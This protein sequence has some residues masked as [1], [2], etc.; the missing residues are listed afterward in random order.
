MEIDLIHSFLIHP[1]KGQEEP[2]EIK[3]ATVT[4]KSTHLYKMLKQV[5]DAAGDECQHDIS[6]SPDEAG[7]QTNVCRALIINYLKNRNL[8]TARKIAERLQAVTTNK[9]GLGLL[10]L[11]SGQKNS[12]S[13]IVIS[14]FRADSGI[15]A[16]EQEETLNVEYL[17]RIFMKNAASYKAA[18]YTGKSYD[19]DFWKGRAIDKQI[20]SKESYISDYWIRDFLNSSFLTTGEAGT[21]RFAD[22][23]KKTMN[24]TSIPA[25]KDE[26][27]ALCKLLPGKDGKVLNASQ[28]LKQHGI[29]KTTQDLI[30]ENFPR[31]ALFH[32]SFKFISEELTKFIAFKTVELSNGGILT[33][34]TQKFDDIFQKETINGESV[35]FSTEGQIVDQRFRK[36]S[37]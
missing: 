22:A 9:S 32:E 31:E 20:N 37:S 36:I 5:Y 30:K 4:S 1:A 34:E 24:N 21:R 23:I 10:F 8:N 14:R 16:E 6:F 19:S 13:K 35:K 15:L 17:E 2:A 18:L 28:I 11:L 27:T 29:S 26:L 33:A 12:Q 3:G 7:N 25:I